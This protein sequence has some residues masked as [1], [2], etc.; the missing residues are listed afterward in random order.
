MRAVANRGP[1]EVRVRGQAMPRFGQRRADVTHG[2][3]DPLLVAGPW[4][5]VGGTAVAVARGLARR[6]RP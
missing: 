4:V 6:V 2:W 5:V 3:I 1:Y